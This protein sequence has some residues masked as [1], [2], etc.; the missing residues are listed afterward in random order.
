M[1]AGDQTR[2]LWL[3]NEMALAMKQKRKIEVV[4]TNHCQLP[5]KRAVR[6]VNRVGGSRNRNKVEDKID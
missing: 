1:L 3:Y 2:S 5:G 6:K 4:V